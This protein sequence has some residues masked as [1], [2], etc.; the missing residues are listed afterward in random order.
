[1]NKTEIMK[2]FYLFSLVLLTTIIAHAQKKSA[3]SNP[4]APGQTA[5]AE[6]QEYVE[7][8]S[9]LTYQFSTP[10][11]S[12][13]I[14]KQYNRYDEVNNIAVYEN[15]SW[16][17]FSQ[18]WGG[19]KGTTTQNGDI[20]TITTYSW[21]P[22][23]SRFI[24]TGKTELERTGNYQRSSYFI[25]DTYTKTFIEQN[26]SE[27]WYNKED[28]DSVLIEY[29]KDNATGELN[30][31]RRTT[32]VYNTNYQKIQENDFSWTDGSWEQTSKINMG[33]DSKGN[34]IQ[35]DWYLKSF[36]GL[37]N[38]RR[39]YYTYDSLNNMVNSRT[40]LLNN[41]EW[42][43]S[44]NYTAEYDD[45]N[46]L[47][48]ELYQTWDFV[49]GQ[50]LNSNKTDYSY[51]EVELKS[52]AATGQ[53]RY[54]ATFQWV[55]VVGWE[56]YSESVTITNESGLPLEYSDKMYD[57]FSGTWNFFNL[58]RYNWHSESGLLL[59]VINGT[60]TAEEQDWNIYSK[61]YYY[62]NGIN[63]FQGVAQPNS[64]NIS[65]FPNPVVDN[66]FIVRQTPSEIKMKLFNSNG[67]LVFSDR[68]SEIAK[69]FDI[70]GFKN[71]LY[72][73]QLDINGE[74]ENHKIIKIN[75]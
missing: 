9:I 34:L 20:E 71:G 53:A 26:K 15:W 57:S 11:D 74:I 25:Y 18:I 49:L 13:L 31:A 32:T 27:Y 69:S 62:Y 54:T 73:V 72:V 1:V 22:D 35:Q 4:I 55:S 24:E 39:D 60:K 64:K 14:Q 56:P 7:A 46:R 23:S 5:F 70:S 6:T 19:Y 58:Y 8:D 75:P 40:E 44:T 43:N 38:N 28:L 47:T 42:G 12:V 50:W 48:L 37:Y 59:A 10:V 21:S 65:V 68:F 52:T 41:N 63:V 2:P 29:Q 61:S 51:N 3:V 67:K 36:D 17:S 45:Q 33:Y 30:Y 16:N 66:I